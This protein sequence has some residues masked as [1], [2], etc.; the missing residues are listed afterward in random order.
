MIEDKDKYAITGIGMINAVG[1]NAYQ[2]CASLRAG[3]ARIVDIPY[4]SY[5]TDRLETIPLSGCPIIGV[6]DGY[7]GLGRWTRLAV[8]AIKDLISNSA[9]TIQQL[10]HSALFLGLPPL[11]R[12]GV[13]ERINAMLGQRIGQW[14]KLEGLED[15][16]TT[17]AEGHASVA[18]GIAAAVRALKSRTIQHAIVGGVD[19]LVEPDTLSEFFEN[20]RLLTEDNPEGF[21][22]G[23]GAA[24][25]VLEPLGQAIQRQAAI[26]ATLE[27]PF[28]AVE[29]VTIRSDEPPNGSGLGLAVRGVFD[30][31]ADQGERT[32]LIICDLNGETYR[33]REFGHTAARMLG[34]V[35]MDWRLWHPAEYMGDTGAAAF[36]VSVCVGARALQKG[37]AA[38]DNILVFGASDDGL[39]G[40]V[41]LRAFS[42]DKPS[43]EQ[44]WA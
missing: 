30:Q 32:G 37:Y 44:Q 15:R 43:E 25:F 11:N 38:A 42:K 5:R 39:R 36:A 14:S 8:E 41:Y 13:D 9:L 23:E 4:F 6:T 17:F 29:P 2:A 26:M 40:A 12:R 21:I 22:P 27:A 34:N 28:T 16:T 18:R 7:L 24:F 35:K 1:R 20:K 10:H 33:A 31:L 19:S 3:I